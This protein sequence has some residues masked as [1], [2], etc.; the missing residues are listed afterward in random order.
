[1]IHLLIESILEPKGWPAGE[2][3]G[4]LNFELQKGE[5]P[6]PKSI[7]IIQLTSIGDVTMT[8]PVIEGLREKYPEA[9][10]AFLVDEPSLNIVKDNPFLDEVIL[11][12]EYR[13]F[14]EIKTKRKT[15]AEVESELGHFIEDLRSKKF[16]LVLNFHLSRRAAIVSKLI[17]ARE[18]IGLNID[19]DENLF[20]HGNLWMYYRYLRM[21]VKREGEHFERFSHQAELNLRIAGVRP[22][23]PRT[24]IF[25][26]DAAE[27]EADGFLPQDELNEWIVGLAPGANWPSRRWRAEKF[28]QLGD[29]LVR[30]YGARIILFGGREDQDLAQQMIGVMQAKP[31][32]TT[33]R[34]SLKGLAALLSKCRVL[35]SNDTGPIH[36]AGAVG[37]PV[38]SICGP[39]FR[40]PYG[41]N[42]HLI[43][44]ADIA[45]RDCAR[46]GCDDHRCMELIGIESVMKAV[47]IQILLLKGRKDEVEG[48][49]KDSSLKEINFYFSG[50]KRPGKFFS[51]LPL[52]KEANSYCMAGKIEEMIQLKFWEHLNCVMCKVSENPISIEAMLGEIDGYFGDG[53]KEDFK[54]EIEAEIERFGRL[55]GFCNQ[56]AGL[57]GEL[58]SRIKFQASSERRDKILAT[59]NLLDEKIKEEGKPGRFLSFLSLPDYV[60]NPPAD[61]RLWVAEESHR[62]YLRKKEA[63]VFMSEAL[64]EILAKL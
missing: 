30:Q 53:K 50:L 46:T 22:Q 57:S 32:D 36:I 19:D 25:I 49:L 35:I 29:E 13:Y 20:L 43:L 26:D 14:E 51:Y 18:A 9:R 42:G 8:T 62:S 34:L 39:S 52:K 60:L 55:E 2:G 61:R 24:T 10:I 28:A 59:L 4:V 44:Q 7:L 11:F 38:I 56:A 21:F 48:L 17:G 40:G 64:R 37:T 27:K 47:E 1:M 6:A 54:R 16:D 15:I 23:D 45:C 3:A 41:G 63:C 12:D 31:I 5:L 33:G 58:H